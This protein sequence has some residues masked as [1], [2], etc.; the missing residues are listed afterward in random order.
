MQ[1]VCIKRN[2]DATC[3][4]D[5]L[6]EPYDSE[7]IH[8]E[9]DPIMQ[10]V[11]AHAENIQ[12]FFRQKRAEEEA[13][14]KAEEEADRE[15]RRRW[16]VGEVR[17][18]LDS[19]QTR[20]YLPMPTGIGGLDKVLNGGFKRGQLVLLGAAPGVGKTA[21]SQWMFE[22]MAKSGVSCLYLNLEM[23]RDQILARTI[24]RIAARQGRRIHADMILQGYKWTEEQKAAV[25]AAADE[26]EKTIAPNLFYN[27][28]DVTADLDDILSYIESEALRAEKLE[29]PAPIVVLDYLQIIRGRDRED[30]ASLIKRA[31]SGLKDYAINH[32]SLVFVIIAHN[33]TSNA[34]GIVSME[35]GRDTS[36]LEYSADLQMAL[37]FTKCLKRDGMKNKTP[38]ELTTEERKYLTLKIVKGRFGG[39]GREIDLYFDGETMTFGEIAKDFCDIADGD[40]MS[41]SKP[42]RRF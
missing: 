31:V 17:H 3:I 8:A 23:S 26:Y 2:S 9:G 30:P 12:K 41:Q 34:S 16:G 35:S 25:M 32:D 13:R 1:S 22:N 11:K 14:R 28:Q 40:I 37:T 6:I 20:K 29:R 4:G 21:L 27:P 38:D 18:F 39:V 33:R 24:S 10:K 7:S 15:Q 19:I 5:T 36:A 42:R